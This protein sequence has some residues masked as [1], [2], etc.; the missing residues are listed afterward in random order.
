MELP[1]L[2]EHRGKLNPSAFQSS[3]RKTPKNSAFINS[4]GMAQK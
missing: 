4:Y 3:G 2:I 1:V